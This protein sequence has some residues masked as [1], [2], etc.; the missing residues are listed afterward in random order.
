MHAQ[1]DQPTPGNHRGHSYKETHMTFD[2]KTY[3]EQALTTA[4]PSALNEE[5]M[6]GNLAG[7]VGEVL[8]AWS[9]ARRDD[10]PREKLI[11]ELKAEMGGVLWQLAGT[12]EVFGLSLQEVA[13]YNLHELAD[14]KARNVISGSGNHR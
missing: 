1:P 10:W 3:Q 12:C 5:Y 11:E 2:F 9:K 7:E 14:R 6:L 8:G 13:E 4:L